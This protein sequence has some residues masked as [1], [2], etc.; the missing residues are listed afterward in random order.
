MIHTKYTHKTGEA[1]SGAQIDARE[2]K[3]LLINFHE[4]SLEMEGN[5]KSDVCA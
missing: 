2:L 4:E 3:K 1:H 5:L